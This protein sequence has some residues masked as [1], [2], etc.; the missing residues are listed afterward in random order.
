M[1]AITTM[2]DEETITAATYLSVAYEQLQYAAFTLIRGSVELL[3][4]DKVKDVA[5][6]SDVMGDFAYSQHPD[7]VLAKYVSALGLGGQAFVYR[8]CS[9]NMHV[10]D[11]SD[12]HWSFVEL[13]KWL[14]SF[15]GVQTTF[16]ECVFGGRVIYME[17]VDESVHVP[18]LE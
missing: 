16:T 13:E 2:L 5:L 10:S 3:G 7:R 14:R 9:A 12:Q 6:I 4:D 1:V 11:G 17:R 8:P 15:R 18:D